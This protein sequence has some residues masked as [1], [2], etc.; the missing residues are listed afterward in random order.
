MTQNPQKKILTKKKKSRQKRKQ[1]KDMAKNKKKKKLWISENLPL[2]DGE[3]YL[4][5]DILD[6]L[7][8]PEARGRNSPMLIYLFI[9]ITYLL[10]MI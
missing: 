7:L 4:K 6:K 9:Y 8:H 1:N 5:Y 2:I 3:T 10:L